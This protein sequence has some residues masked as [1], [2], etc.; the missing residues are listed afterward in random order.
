MQ[1]SSDITYNISAIENLPFTIYFAASSHRSHISVGDMGVVD[2]LV[3]TILQDT[4]A[5][6]VAAFCVVIA[7]VIIYHRI[8]SK[9][10]SRNPFASDSRL[11]YKARLE[12]Q[13]DRDKVLKQG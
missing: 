7:S 2:G 12:D 1:T 5:S 4:T 6:V 3:S 10:A 11:S 13:A 9:P 8:T